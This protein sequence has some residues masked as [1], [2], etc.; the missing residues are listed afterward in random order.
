MVKPID[1]ARI[2]NWK[3]AYRDET[4]GIHSNIT[5]MLWNYA[6]FRIANRII[7]LENAKR[8]DTFRLNQIIFESIKQGYWYGF[9]VGARRLLDPGGLNGIKGV[10]SL[11]SVLND[12]KVC[13]PWVNRRVY[14]EHVCAAEYDTEALWRANHDRLI[15]AGGKAIWGDNRIAISEY[16]HKHFDQLSGVSQDCRAPQDVINPDI[17][18][19]IEGRLKKLDRIRDHVS[20]HL[21]HAGN[22][23]SRENNGLNEFDLRDAKNTL[24]E[25]K[26][27]ADLTGLW[28]AQDVSG[29]LTHFIGDKFHGLD[30]P[31]VDTSDIPDLEVHWRKIEEDIKTWRL[32]PESL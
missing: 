27:I 5:E 23:A 30:Q 12:I 22:K 1:L 14:V 6:V 25:L 2:A 28:F 10:Y 26:E 24:K 29:P 21:A 19:K 20:T 7:Y 31:M 3:A 13:A 17:F 11:R 8:N 18:A 4:T 9:L 15:A 16:A 32:A